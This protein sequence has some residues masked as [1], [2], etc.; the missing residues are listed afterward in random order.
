[1]FLSFFVYNASSD[2]IFL[3]NGRTLQGQ[4]ISQSVSKI[5]LKTEIGTLMTINPTQIESVQKI[6]LEEKHIKLGDL[7]VSKEQYEGAVEEYKIALE[8]NPNLPEI[9]KKLEDTVL[10]AV[11]PY[12]EKA[13][14]S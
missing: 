1:V 8:I 13:D 5:E 12:F 14:K 11:K 4:I 7:L 6:P 10:T 3:K 9:K 2:I